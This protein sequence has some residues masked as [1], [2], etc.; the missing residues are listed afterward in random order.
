MTTYT[1]LYMDGQWLNAD[2]DASLAVINPATEKVVA[3]VPRGNANDVNRAVQAA[4]KAFLSWSQTSAAERK[5]LLLAIADG[6]E[7]R[8]QDLTAAISATMGCPQHIAGWLQ[9][10]GPIEAMRLFAEL[11]GVTE[12]VDT[13]DGALVVYESAGVCAFINPWNYPLHQFVGKVGAAL[14]AGCTMVVKPAEQTPLQ[15]FIMAEIIDAAGVP[16]G[17]FNL[18]PGYGVDVGETLCTHPEVDVVSFTGSTRAGIEV[19]KAA[20]P[21][22]KR[23]T[24]ELGGKSPLIITEDADLQAAVQYG[25][26]DVMLNSGQ[27]CVALTRMLVPAAKYDEAVRLAKDI[28][29]GLVVGMQ[30]DAF[31][32]PISSRAQQQKILEYI[33][34]GL[35]EG[36]TLVCGG[37]DS[38]VVSGSRDDGTGYSGAGYSA[39]G[40]YVA[41]TVFANVHNQMRI[42]REEIFG[43]VLCMIP[44]TDIDEAVEIANDTPYGLA[45][46]V[47]AGSEEGAIAIARRIRAGQCLMNGAVFNYNAPFG[48]YKQSGNGREFSA[49]GV[50]EFLEIKAMLQPQ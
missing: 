19:A 15:D 46:A 3:E 48:G 24:Q 36:A 21:T 5:R 47:Y 23:V 10:D 28:A 40:Y 14:A 18:V 37:L 44:Y 30:E 17:V 43:P 11:T 45:S 50:H 39:P 42:A 4:R 22:V 1:Q 35:D 38:P 9:V 20:A 7:A 32:G 13:V 49:A 12:Q 29:E 34:I 25:V 33:Q 8:K 26:E 31:L 27:T 2:S 6:M 16:A 41:P